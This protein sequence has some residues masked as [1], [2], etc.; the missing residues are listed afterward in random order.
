[1]EQACLAVEVSPQDTRSSLL[2]L[3]L[4][5]L[6][7]ELPQRL[8]FLQGPWGG[9]LLAA[10]QLYACGRTPLH[11][12]LQRVQPSLA[13][14]LVTGMVI[15][16]D[17][18]QRGFLQILDCNVGQPVMEPAASAWR[19]LCWTVLQPEH[20]WDV[21]PAS[22]TSSSISSSSSTGGKQPV[23]G[24]GAPTEVVLFGMP[25]DLAGERVPPVDLHLVA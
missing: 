9:L 22:S 1:L 5:L 13:P 25:S 23:L 21:N 10:L 14:D 3:V 18:G 16:D 4:L 2:L 6:R 8:A 11:E 7:A 15:S 17:P 24:P 12:A 19:L 20:G